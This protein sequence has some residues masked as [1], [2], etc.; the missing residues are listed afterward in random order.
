MDTSR[1]LVQLQLVVGDRALLHDR[2]LS[3]TTEM[4]FSVWHLPYT[5]EL[6]LFYH[7]VSN[8]DQNAPTTITA[9]CE[10]R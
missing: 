3:L 5:L 8:I 1:T 6:G 9:V 10:Q 7:L 2:V 4:R